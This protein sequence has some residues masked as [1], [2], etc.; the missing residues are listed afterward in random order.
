ML[1]SLALTFHYDSVNDLLISLSNIKQRHKTPNQTKRK[2]QTKHKAKQC[3]KSHETK[4]E[5]QTQAPTNP[6]KK[7]RGHRQ[8]KRKARRSERI[9]SGGG[10]LNYLQMYSFQIFFSFKLSGN[11]GYLYDLKIKLLWQRK[12]K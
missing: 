10:Y 8:G 12:W 1:T 9:L 6:N 2:K 5:Q 11:F 4:A 3:P 7:A